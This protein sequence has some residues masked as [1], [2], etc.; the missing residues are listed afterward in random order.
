MYTGIDFLEICFEWDLPPCHLLRQLFDHICPDINKKD[1]TAILKNPPSLTSL[2]TLDRALQTL[3]NFQHQ[4]LDD[5]NPDPNAAAEAFLSRLV[6]DVERS[7]DCDMMYGPA[8]DAARHTAG[9][10]YEV[11]LCEALDAAGIAYSTEKDL[12]DTG[13]FKTPDARLLVP[14][15]IKGH[16]ISWVE[17]K[18]TFGDEKQ[19]YKYS[20][21]QYQ[22]YCNR[23]GSGMVIYWHGYLAH[24]Q[25][26]EE[27]VLLADGLP[28]IQEI[29]MLPRLPLSL[30]D[31][32]SPSLSPPLAPPTKELAQEK[33]AQ[34][35]SEGNMSASLNLT[36][37]NLIEVNG[38]PD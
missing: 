33:S 31:G 8:S 23:F 19:H 18:A 27:N 11:R 16:V 2:F 15:A 38:E 25:H 12:R 32:S 9:D 17:S 21:E 36:S 37:I 1:I 7:V 29:T 3:Q 10:E 14:I 20:R 22:S 6:R 13:H 5:R 34:V 4:G 24:L 30:A 28:P 35:F 26:F